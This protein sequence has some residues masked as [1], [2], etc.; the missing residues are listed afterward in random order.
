[1]FTDSLIATEPHGWREAQARH[2]R[3]QFGSMPRTCIGASA[4]VAPR[5][6]SRSM[7][8]S[9]IVCAFCRTPATLWAIRAAND[10]ARDSSVELMC[11]R[12][13]MRHHGPVAPQAF[14]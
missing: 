5:A 12:G 10:E 9:R 7:A 3:S 4:A 14:P 13:G 11:G 1:M 8:A 2:L 6:L